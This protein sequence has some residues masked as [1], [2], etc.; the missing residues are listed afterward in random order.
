MQLCNYAIKHTL[1]PNTHDKVREGI[2]DD[3]DGW[4]NY[5][6][7]FFLSFRPPGEHIGK[8]R[9]RSPP[10]PFH[11]VVAGYQT[12]AHMSPGEHIGQGV[13]R[14]PPSPFHA[15]VAGYKEKIR[16]RPMVST[17]SPVPPLIRGQIQRLV[18][19]PAGEGVH[20]GRLAIRVEYRGKSHPRVERHRVYRVPNG[21]RP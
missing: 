9:Y 14:S 15:V 19:I 21:D 2:H 20:E 5:M 1:Y 17:V 4:R 7:W 11:V 6:S 3:H 12:N 10:S 13:Y 18:V 16:F 8:G